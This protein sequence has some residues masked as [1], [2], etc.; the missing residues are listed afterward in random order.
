MALNRKSHFVDKLSIRANRSV[1]KCWTADSITVAKLVILINARLVPKTHKESSTVPQAT[2]RL[3]SYLADS[4][5]LAQIQ[6]Q[7]AM[8]C[9]SDSYPV[10]NTNASKFAIT[11]TVCDVTSPL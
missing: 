6:Y 3:K 8:P 5:S 4:E 10:E 2:I 9:V 7:L 1:A 11:T